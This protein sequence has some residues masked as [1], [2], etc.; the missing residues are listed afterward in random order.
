MPNP[1]PRVGDIWKFNGLGI[2]FYYL[3]V[4]ETRED[5][6]YY[7]ADSVTLLSFSKD[8]ALYITE[9]VSK[10]IADSRRWNFIS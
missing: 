5:H 2:E 6:R 7:D 4:E 8:E 10:M 9:G 1:R 3:I